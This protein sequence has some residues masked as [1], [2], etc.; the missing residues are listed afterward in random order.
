MH[1]RRFL[2]ICG[3]NGLILG[4]LTLSIYLSY[5]R[6]DEMPGYFLMTFLPMVL[7]TIGGGE[8]LMRSF[9]PQGHTDGQS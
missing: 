2:A 6:G 3:L 4:E 5:G 9:F 1:I 7:I 8:F